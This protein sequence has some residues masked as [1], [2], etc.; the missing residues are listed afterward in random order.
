M[1]DNLIFCM[2][3]GTLY[4]P[5]YVNTLYSMVKRNLTLDFRMVCFTDDDFFVNTIQISSMQRAC[6][7]VSLRLH[8]TSEMR[9]AA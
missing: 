6:E 1:S 3:W 4:G 5:E 2:K 8:V 7:F 9:Y